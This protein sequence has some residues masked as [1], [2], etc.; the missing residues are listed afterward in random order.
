MLV[1]TDVAA[2]GLDIDDL[3]LVVNYELPH[4]PEDYIHR[5]GRTGR[6]GATGE[7]ISLVAPEEEKLS[8]RDR[9]AA[10]EED[11]R[12]STPEGFDATAAACAAPAPS[13]GGGNARRQ[14]PRARG[15]PAIAAATAKGGA[16]RA[17][18]APAPIA[19]EPRE[20][21]AMVPREPRAEA[22]S[23]GDARRAEREAAYAQNP[24]QPIVTRPDA[25]RL[26]QR[27]AIGG[28]RAHGHVGGARRARS[29][30]C[31]RSGKCPSPRRSRRVVRCH[32]AVP[33]AAARCRRQGGLR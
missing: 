10:E 29:Q 11:R 33:M 19:R 13:A 25:R 5:I 8:R 30:R 26:R 2:R 32:G 6:A 31:C 15:A 14:E 24:D 27:A 1:A 18:A 9:E 4:V 23:Y 16:S 12:S 7:A 22:P 21:G 3:P 28:H 20:R 17:S